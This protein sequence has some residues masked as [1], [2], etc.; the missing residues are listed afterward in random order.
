MTVEVRDLTLRYD[1]TTAFVVA[2]ALAWRV[3]RDI[4]IRSTS[5]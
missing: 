3:L 4:P 1:R 5:A 2:A